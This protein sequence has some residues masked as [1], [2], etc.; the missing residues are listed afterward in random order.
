MARQLAQGHTAGRW[1]SQDFNP[2]PMFDVSRPPYTMMERLP[3]GGLPLPK[4]CR[5]ADG[6]AR[7]PGITSGLDFA[8]GH[9]S[10]PWGPGLRVTPAGAVPGS[11]EELWQ[12]AWKPC[13]PRS[14]LAPTLFSG[15]SQPRVH[16]LDISGGLATTTFTFRSSFPQAVGVRVS[17][18]QV[19][20]TGRG[21]LGRALATALSTSP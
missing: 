6:E 18:T 13:V 8:G 9:G 14:V 19:P 15:P 20:C 16:T 17:W 21:L 12:R 11:G 1:Q 5:E 7:F 4:G 2:D 10:R 3:S